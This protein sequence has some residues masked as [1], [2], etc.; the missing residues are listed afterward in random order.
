MKKIYLLMMLFITSTVMGQTPIITMILDGDCTGGT[1]KVLEIYAQ[2][3]VDFSNYTLEKQGNGNPW[4]DAFDLTP[5]GTITDDF[6]YLYATNTTATNFST[7]F[8]NVTNS[9]EVTGS[10]MNFNGDDGVR[11]IETTT[12]NVIDTYGVELID[13]T[14]EIWEYKDGYAKRMD[15]TGP[16]GVFV[17]GN[18]TFANGGVDGLCGTTTF[19]VIANA[20]SYIYTASGTP[21]VTA[22]AG[23]VAGF[24]QIVGAP[25]DEESFDVSGIDLT[26]DIMIS[27]NSGDYEISLTSGTGFGASVT[28]PFGTGV[29]AATPVYVR[30]NGAVIA[31]PSNGDLLITS[32]GSTDVTVTL[33]GQVVDFTASTVAAVTGIDADGVGTSN[34][35]FVTLTGVLHCDNFRGTG[36]GYDLTLIDD[37]NDGIMVFS[38]DDIGTFMPTEGDEVTIDGE[39]SQ[40]NGIIQINPITITVVSQGA[41]LQAPT[42]VTMLDESTESQFIK[43]ENLTLVNGEATWPDNGNI[44]VTDGTT[45]FMVRVTYAS[46]LA[47]AAT[48]L[49]AFN[50]MGIGKQ[51]DNSNPFTEGYQI[52]PCSVEDVVGLSDNEFTGVSVYPNPVTDVLNITNENGLLETVEV[53]SASGS[54]VYTSS[55]SSAN[56]TVNTANLNAGVYFVNVRTANSVKT[57]KVIK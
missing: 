54:V 14:G 49:G 32:T 36:S 16:D 53:V 22:S 26:A 11:I 38:F 7:E 1:P 40:F 44:D 21:T 56:V 2:G 57:F 4:A 28:I 25:S 45:T 13:G 17:P 50:M 8:P 20:G 48:P 41:A 18:W 34:G 5:L 39:I 37:N 30:L 46:S 24:T 52:F 6:V 9:Y 19:E 43:I 31:N 42:V 27:V 55:V 29:V 3:T 15:Y 33:E 23:V 12:S 51:F 35:E 10:A 47:N